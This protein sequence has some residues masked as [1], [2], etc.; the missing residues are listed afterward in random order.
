MMWLP[1]CGILQINWLPYMRNKNDCN[2]DIPKGYIREEN[3]HATNGR[4]PN[5]PRIFN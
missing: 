4:R 1:R 2:G 3:A 5:E